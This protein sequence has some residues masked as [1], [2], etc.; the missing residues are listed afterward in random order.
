MVRAR[1]YLI[2]R[3]RLRRGRCR[4][5]DFVV[6][7]LN[8]FLVFLLDDCRGVICWLLVLA[9]EIHRAVIVRTARLLM[10]LLLQVL[11]IGRRIGVLLLQLIL[12]LFLLL[13]VYEALAAHLLLVIMMVVKRH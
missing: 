6:Q 11:L 13:E 12:L 1:R 10:L 8:I 3:D 4:Y 7:C 2:L 9:L 5:H